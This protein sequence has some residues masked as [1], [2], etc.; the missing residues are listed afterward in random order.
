[1]AVDLN[2]F[3]SRVVTWGILMGTIVLALMLGTNLYS[4]E[5]QMDRQIEA[6]IQST[7]AAYHTVLVTPL[8]EYDYAT[9]HDIA[10]IWKQTDGLSYLVI[11]NN[12]GKRL[13][14]TGLEANAVLPEPGTSGSMRNIR[15]DVNY[16][17]QRYG[18]VQYGMSTD[19]LAIARE[20][21]ILYNAF[22]AL[23]GML[24]LWVLLLIISRHIVKPLLNLGKAAER[25]SSGDYDVRLEP[26]GL[27]ELD[28]LSAHFRTMAQTVCSKISMLEWQAQHD[29][30]TDVFN[31]RAFEER[32]AD[33]LADPSVADITMLYIDLDQFKAIN[34]SCGHTAGDSLLTH[35]AQLLEA[36]LKD[37]FIARIGGDEFGAIVTDGDEHE[38]F[39]LAQGII[40]SIAN[41]HFVWENQTY[42][43]GA[44]IGIA[45]SCAIESRSIKELMIAA[46][47]ACFGAKELGRN[48]IQI[49]LPDDDYFRQR[50]MELRS[51]AELD[52]VL[53]E[54][55]FI[56]YH[57]RYT[58]LTK[59]RPTHAE[60]LLRVRN[61]EGGIDPPANFIHA[62]ERYNLMPHIDKWVIESA[63]R[64]IAQWEKD[65]CDV[66]VDRFGINVSGASL[67]DERFPDFVLGQI[68]DSGVNPTRLCFE[69][70]ES[71]AV[72]NIK[73]ALHFIECVRREGAT[74]AL[75]DFGSG[76]SSFAYLKQ[77]QA[78]YLK[79]DGAFVRDI[80]VDP[81]NLATVEAIVMLARA[82]NLSTIA[83]FV[84]KGEILDI[85]RGLGV[86]YAQGFHCHKP[87][88]LSN[89]KCR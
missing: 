35:I 43:V 40:D 69:I 47:T 77:F 34:D 58:S 70:T 81:T 49:Y 41:I 23:V 11:M 68:R 2:S 64:Q 51:V 56:L 16:L 26:T 60:I 4:V 33:L 57:Q 38:I 6:R 36:R 86:D 42:R 21:L 67:S 53:A 55:R 8:A 88:P 76:L 17:G 61:C 73:P 89:L 71:A 48:R 83:E 46:D 29:A 13:I 7:T 39:D 20:R 9:L 84:H 45:S 22:V 30:L 15:F 14:E 72:A 37:A 25:I 44:S 10:D 78:D 1:M 65:H 79:V 74:V 62:A 18:S 85:I 75:D 87:E 50:R 5:Q 27:S 19:Y 32:T 52:S 63:C 3:R 28:R 12:T 24:L 54:G 31:R 80:D 82:H 59:E 66:G